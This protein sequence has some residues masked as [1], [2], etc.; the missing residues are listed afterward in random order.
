M[1][2]GYVFEEYLN[3]HRDNL[4]V[5]KDTRSN[6]R[7]VVLRRLEPA[8]FLLE[9]DLNK[10]YY[11]KDP[12]LTFGIDLIRCHREQRNITPYDDFF[13]STRYRDQEHR[14]DTV[15][16]TTNVNC[17]LIA[18]TN[19]RFTAPETGYVSRVEVSQEVFT[20][21]AFTLYLKTRNPTVY[22]MIPFGIDDLRIAIGPTFTHWDFTFSNARINPYGGR[23]MERD[24]RAVDRIGGDLHEEA[25]HALLKEHKYP[26]RPDMAAR[27]E[28]ERKSKAL[29]K[30]RSEI[31]N[32]YYPAFRDL[33]EERVR[34]QGNPEKLQ[35]IANKVKEL[36]S[37][38]GP[39]LDELN[40]QLKELRAEAHTLNL[41]EEK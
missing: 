1:K 10:R 18:T 14:W 23:E 32:V 2:E 9:V 20:N 28:N 26:P 13:V 11:T 16:W 27:M 33:D 31:E 6:P 15:F 22:A 37:K 7:R 12:K 21:K 29:R 35:E 36:E 17:G 34:M 5:E 38:Y 40:N 8:S 19:R 25:L 41:P 4:S 39:R 30:E 24:G 3:P